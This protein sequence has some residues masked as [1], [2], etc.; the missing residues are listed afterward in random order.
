VKLKFTLAIFGLSLLTNLIP[1]DVSAFAQTAT[2]DCRATALS[3]A[4]NSK[5]EEAQ[6]GWSHLWRYCKENAQLGQPA[7]GE[8]RVVFFGDSIT[9]AWNLP[10]FFPGKPYVNRGVSGETTSQMLL[11]FRQDVIDLS[12]KVVVILA[13]TNDIAGNTGPI[14]IKAIE[15]NFASMAEIAQANGVHIVLSSVL[16]AFDY[17]WR[18]GQ[19]PVEKIAAL[20]SWL[21]DYATSHRLVY[22]DYYTVMQDARHGL[23]P[24]L[25]GDGVHPNAVG[26]SVM[27]P[28][29]EKAIAQA[30]R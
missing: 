23:P 26:Y 6:Y 15:E 19:E 17:P 29:A 16:P 2:D 5:D 27:Q 1:A 4:N 10:T 22:L 18:H 20:N 13:G 7:A 8:S 28:L 14:T 24:E 25:S 12:P 3:P 21:K 11:R 9:E 30:G